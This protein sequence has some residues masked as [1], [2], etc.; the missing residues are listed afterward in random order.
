LR[1]LHGFF[2]ARPSWD[3]FN[4]S[5][6]RTPDRIASPASLP[7]PPR[8]IGNTCTSLEPAQP[9]IAPRNAAAAGRRAAQIHA[10]ICGTRA[11]KPSPAR[12]SGGAARG[13]CARGAWVLPCVNIIGTRWASPSRRAASVAMLRQG[14]SLPGAELGGG[15]AG[16][17]IESRSA[18][19]WFSHC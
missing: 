11:Q 8:H 6:S 9:G 12:R 10:R 7:G 19:P 13:G 3:I 16:S 15:A 17:S 18:A 2:V 5:A 1:L 14:L 4:P